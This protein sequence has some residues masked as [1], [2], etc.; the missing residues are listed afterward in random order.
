MVEEN[1]NDRNDKDTDDTTV[2]DDAG[3]KNDDSS[4]R[5]SEAEAKERPRRR[6]DSSRS[7]YTRVVSRG[8]MFK[9]KICRFCANKDLV[10]DYKN[11]EVLERFITDRGKILPRRITGTCSKHQRSLANAIKRARILAL[12][13]FV[14]K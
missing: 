7:S 1:N 12:L 4:N 8:P 2:S 11:I 6:S 10:I 5:T 3:K 13:P 14:V 9:R